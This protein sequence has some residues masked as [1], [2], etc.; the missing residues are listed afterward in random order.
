M[1]LYSRRI[2]TNRIG[3]VLSMMAM[4]FGLDR[5]DVDPLDPVL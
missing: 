3:I 4:S 2:L 1:N 5:P